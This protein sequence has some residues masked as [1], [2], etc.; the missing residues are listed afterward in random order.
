ML[1][2]EEISFF[3]YGVFVSLKGKSEDEAGMKFMSRK[4]AK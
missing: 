1:N 4:M 3:F 2:K